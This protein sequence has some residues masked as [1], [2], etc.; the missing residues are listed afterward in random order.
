MRPAVCLLR[1]LLY[2]ACRASVFELAKRRANLFLP[3]KTIIRRFFANLSNN[4]TLNV[5]SLSTIK[6][7]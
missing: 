4:V 7:L 6:S 1:K 2:V 3:K 5:V